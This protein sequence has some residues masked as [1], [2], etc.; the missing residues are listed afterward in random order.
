MDWVLAR[1]D[2]IENALAARHL[3]NGTLVLYDVSSAAFEGRTCPL[4]AIGHARDGV[5]GRLQIV[6]GLLCSPAGVPV[7]IEVF[8]GNTADPKTLAAQI[9]KLK[10]RFGLSGCAWWVIGA[11]SPPRASA[12]SCARAAGLDHRVA[13]PA[14]Q[15]PR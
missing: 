3:A 9:T 11:C 8:E 14:D 2:A 7:A 5:K 10:T 12:T 15:G 6:Y 4:G 1:K 13:R